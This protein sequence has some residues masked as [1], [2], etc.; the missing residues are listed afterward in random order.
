LKILLSCKGKL[1]PKTFE[2]LKEF[3]GNQKRLPKEQIE[4][5]LALLKNKE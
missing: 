2:K 3:I 4:I 5:I 1:K